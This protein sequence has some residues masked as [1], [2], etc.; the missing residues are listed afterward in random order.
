MYVSIYKAGFV[1]VF[2]TYLLILSLFYEAFTPYNVVSWFEIINV[3]RYFGSDSFHKSQ[4]WLSF[5][6]L[7]I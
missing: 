1:F 6:I 7:L 3:L 5:H 4:S 2:L